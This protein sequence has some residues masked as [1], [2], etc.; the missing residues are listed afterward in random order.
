[1]G[2]MGGKVTRYASEHG[3]CVSS[4]YIKHKKLLCE[5]GK[6]TLN[7]YPPSRVTDRED[8]TDGTWATEPPQ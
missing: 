7:Y 3:M 4:Y 8:N 2:K 1:M 5:D 6:G